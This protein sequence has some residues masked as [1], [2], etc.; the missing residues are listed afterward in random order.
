MS[1]GLC[2]TDK[3]TLET[4]H[5][6]THHDCVLVNILYGLKIDRRKTHGGISS[7]STATGNI[8]GSKPHLKS[9]HVR[10]R[11]A[12]AN[13]VSLA[14]WV[15]GSKPRS[16][17]VRAALGLLEFLTG[18]NGTRR[19]LKRSRDCRVMSF[20]QRRGVPGFAVAKCGW[21]RA[22]V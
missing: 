21:A 17:S 6:R 16:A 13:K 4:R 2:N 7:F 14:Q 11:L 8:L 10:Q 22:S 12:D 19:Y 3:P 9:V 15:C 18:S 1:D 20:G 5:S